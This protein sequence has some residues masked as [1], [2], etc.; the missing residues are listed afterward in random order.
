MSTIE[1]T[2]REA[3]CRDRIDAE[4]AG[5]LESLKGWMTHGNDP[6]YI[7]PEA[8]CVAIAEARSFFDDEGEFHDFGL[9]FEYVA[10]GSAADQDEGYFR[11]LMSTGGPGDEL[12]FYASPLP[13]RAGQGCPGG[14]NLYRA[15]YWFLDWFDGASI[16]VTQ[17]AAARWCWDQFN[18]V[19]STTHAFDQAQG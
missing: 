12:R 14:W 10:P 17:E 5:R 1:I 15:E 6:D 18:E 7:D 3:K 16:D 2:E 8:G 11:L 19:E 13:G 4:W 9:S